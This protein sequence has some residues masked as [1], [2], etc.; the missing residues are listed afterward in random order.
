MKWLYEGVPSAWFVFF[1]I[2]FNRAKEMITHTTA[3]QN[4]P[5]TSV[6]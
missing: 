2:V 5:I 1:L 4:P 6:A 3:R